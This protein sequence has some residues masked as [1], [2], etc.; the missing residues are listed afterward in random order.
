MAAQTTAYLATPAGTLTGTAAQQLQQLIEEKYVANFLVTGEPY[1]DWRRT[2]YPALSNVPAALN[3]GNGGV[4]PRVLPY[5]QQ[6]TDANPNLKPL[7]DARAAS[8]S[9]PAVRVF[10][11]VRP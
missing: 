3:P 2:G 1:S 8:L 9:A 11:D 4:I 5:P 10:W 6:E 7:Q